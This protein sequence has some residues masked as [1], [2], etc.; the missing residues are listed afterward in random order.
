[1]CVA[2]R[3]CFS[4]SHTA[5]AATAAAATAAAAVAMT[6]NVYIPKDKVS[7]VHTGYGFV[8]MHSILDAEY[9]LKIMNGVKL[10][11]RPIRCNKVMRCACLFCSLAWLVD[12]LL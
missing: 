11:G 7:N 9:A 1:M 3:L 12:C 5:A 4:R 8:E 10:F 2:F 6:V